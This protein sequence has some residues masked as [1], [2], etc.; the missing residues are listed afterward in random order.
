M[1]RK[2]FFLALIILYAAARLALSQPALANPRA[3]DDTT[4]YL[5]I[6]NQPLLN[7]DFWGS[8]RPFVFPLL[9]KIAHQDFPTA[10]FLQLGFSILAWTLLALSVAA[11][12]R[13]LGLS[14]LS[15]GLILALSLVSPLAGWDFTMLTESL[16]VSWFVVFLAAAFWL[17]RAWKIERVILLI[18]VGF[19]L[20]F[21]RD[22]DA[23]LLLMLAGLLSL[24]VLLRWTQP[25]TLILVAAFLGIF[26]LNNADA[27][28]GGRWVFPLFNLIGRRVLPEAQAVQFFE[29][30]CAMPVTPELMA[31]KGEFANGQERA[32][33]E[34]PALADFRAWLGQSG[35]SCYMRWLVTHPLQSGGEAF[36][37]FGAL[38][39]FPAVDHY[40][41][42]D[43]TPSLP[44]PLERALYP[45][46]FILWIWSLVS[47]AA[48]IAL[49]FRAW[50]TNPL[51]GAFILLVLPIFPHLFIT[52]H[53]DAMAPA[54]HALSVGLELY[55][56]LWI[57]VL[58]LAEQ[59]ARRA[60]WY[61]AQL[62]KAGDYPQ[63]H[64]HHSKP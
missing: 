48:L 46:R 22:T 41:S 61:F 35:K 16:S 29:T 15:F 9:L 12:F 21:T 34:D 27:E 5:R 37:E 8:S 54:R 52:W 44:A 57:L 58:L 11:S 30:R 2:I 59:V 50:Q 1:R 28:L 10:A 64:V 47:L 3:L 17:L 60:G 49:L 39:A 51:W 38:I 53:G 13:T 32:F 7:V 19:F 45:D 36:K 25:R 62:K 14:L 31:L 26:L 55:L 6:S 56:S 18:L 20:A 40:F 42:H 4:A 63:V 23:Y 33:Y 43:Y 24:A